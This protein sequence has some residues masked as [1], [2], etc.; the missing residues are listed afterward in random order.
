MSKNWVGI[1]ALVVSLAACAP[2]A[3]TSTATPVSIE[4]TPGMAV[5]Y[6]VRT[7]PDLSYLTA[8][9]VIAGRM[10]GATYAGSYIRVEVPAGRHLISGY[11]SDNGSMTVDA[12]AD[13]IYFVQHTVSGSWRATNPMSFFRM[14]DEARGRA[15]MAGALKV[16]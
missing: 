11:A 13:R 3:P 9:V 4:G 5:I 8:P 2:L 14:I 7:N 15:A 12:Q 16:G 1:L 10:V 6:I